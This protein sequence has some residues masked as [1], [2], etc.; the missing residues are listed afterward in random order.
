M[1]IIALVVSALAADPTIIAGTVTVPAQIVENHIVVVR[2]TSELPNA[3]TIAIVLWFGPDPASEF[4]KKLSYTQNY[5]SESMRLVAALMPR[6][7]AQTLVVMHNPTSAEIVAWFAT[8][9]TNL[10]GDKYREVFI[11]V[12]GPAVGGDTDEEK[13]FMRDVS[14]PNQNGLAFADL[15]RSV[16]TLAESS[17]WILDS[18]RNITGA[19]DQGVTSFGPTA[20]DIAKVDGLREPLAISS[21]ASGRYGSEGL[22]AATAEVIVQSK[23]EKLTFNTLYY[24]GIKMKVPTL[25]TSTSVGIL[26]NDGWDH[27]LDRSVLIGGASAA[28]TEIAKLPITS[29]KKPEQNI[30]SGW[31]LAGGGV[32]ALIGGGITTAGALND[33]D[34]LTKYNLVGGESQ[35]ELDVATRSYHT[36]TALA[37]SLG[38]AGILALAGGLTWAI[39]D[40]GDQKVTLVPTGNGAAV[41]GKF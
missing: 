38:G 36:N 34:T 17:V 12:A 8:E 21:S 18:S 19:L 33:Y 15:V 11:S 2:Q 35:T 16:A 9:R 32:A 30:S 10:D 13:L 24:G 37:A 41:S 6:L 25:D 14:S 40:N 39:L 26:P 3:S 29:A 28:T 20:D 7:D 5:E 22:I 23:G 1:F 4:G 27:N 31:Y